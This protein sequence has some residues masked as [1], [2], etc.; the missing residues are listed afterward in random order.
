MLAPLYLGLRSLEP[1]RES[2]CPHG[3]FPVTEIPRGHLLVLG[4]LHLVFPSRTISFHC[5]SEGIL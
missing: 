4:K 1:K 5:E 3:D 2:T